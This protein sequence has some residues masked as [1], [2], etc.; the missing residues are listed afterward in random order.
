MKLYYAPGASSLAPHIALRESGLSFELV[1]VDLGKHT[2]GQGTDY[3]TLNAKGYV[4]LLELDDGKRIAEVAVVLQYI[5]D[6]KPGSLAPE[7]GTMERYRVMEW[8]NFIGTEIHKGLGP[9]WKPSITDSQRAEILAA[10]GRRLD[11]VSAA[12]ATH[13]YLMGERFGIADAYLF[14]VVNWHTFLK[15]GLDKWP[16]LEQFQARVAARPKVIEALR[17]EHL[18][19]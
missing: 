13:P 12:L 19:G 4:P 9:V 2:I 7:Y 1:R 5:A 10:V 18:L 17:A 8:L 14:T 16:A 6:R 3:Y 15:F 11:F